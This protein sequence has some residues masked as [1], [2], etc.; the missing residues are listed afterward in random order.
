[1]PGAKKGGGEKGKWFALLLLH[2]GTVRNCWGDAEKTAL[3]AFPSARQGKG[4]GKKG[5]PFV[6]GLNSPREKQWS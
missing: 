3:N 5:P 2:G 6:E 4:G 1:M